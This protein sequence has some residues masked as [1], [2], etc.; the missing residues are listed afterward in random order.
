MSIHIVV[1]LTIFVMKNVSL[2]GENATCS[3]ERVFLNTAT[4]N[5]PKARYS[6]KAS[7]RIVGSGL[8]FI[9]D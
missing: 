2:Y 6:A 1:T 3:S 9:T 4:R 5:F 7:I 8:N